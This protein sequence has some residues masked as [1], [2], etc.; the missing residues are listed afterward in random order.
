M[1]QMDVSLLSVENAM[2]KKRLCNAG[3]AVVNSFL[4]VR[5]SCSTPYNTTSPPEPYSAGGG[6]AALASGA[7]LCAAL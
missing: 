3:R 4:A 5:H 2:P 1:L 6:G 7:A